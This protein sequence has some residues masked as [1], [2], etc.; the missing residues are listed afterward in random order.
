MYVN[1]VAHTNN[2]DGVAQVSH[3]C[4]CARAR[5]CVCVC[6]CICMRACVCVCVCVSVCMCVHVRDVCE[7][8]LTARII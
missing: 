6:V 4:M 5:V 2:V 7:C 1:T 8:V 3:V